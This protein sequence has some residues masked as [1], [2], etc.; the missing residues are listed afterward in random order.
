MGNT[1]TAHVESGSVS[2]ISEFSKDVVQ[3]DEEVGVTSDEEAETKGAEFDSLEDQQELHLA[4][5]SEYSA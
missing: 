5:N 3:S 4:G 2:M 1:I